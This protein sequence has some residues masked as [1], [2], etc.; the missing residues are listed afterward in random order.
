MFCRCFVFFVVIEAI[1]SEIT[2]CPK[3]TINKVPKKLLNWTSQMACN[4]FGG[5][6]FTVAMCHFLLSLVQ[7][8]YFEKISLVFMQL[9]TKKS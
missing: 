5:Y 3:Q 6:F 2:L 1:G 8:L 7:L 4:F 9:E